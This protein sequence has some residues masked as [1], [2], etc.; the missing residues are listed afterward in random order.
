ML[1]DVFCTHLYFQG[2]SGEAGPQGAVG[3]P[4]PLVSAT[5]NSRQ[6]Q[7]THMN[8]QIWSPEINVYRV[9]R[10]VSMT[11]FF[12]SGTKRSTRP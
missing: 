2:V 6:T 10:H 7:N 8:F 11:F 12:S 3:L 9:F 1:V 5:I 4:G